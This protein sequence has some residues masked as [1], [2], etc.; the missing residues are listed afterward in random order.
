MLAVTAYVCC[1]LALL[2]ITTADVIYHCWP[3][4][5]HDEQRLLP[6]LMRVRVVQPR[7]NQST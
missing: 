7:I 6:K 1:V 4:L 3:M 5:V 2:E